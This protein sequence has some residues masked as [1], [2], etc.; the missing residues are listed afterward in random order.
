MQNTALC[1]PIFK[2]NKNKHFCGAGSH[3]ELCGL[4][5]ENVSM[6]H[7]MFQVCE[8][9]NRLPY[10]PRAC[11]DL[12]KMVP[13]PRLPGHVAP[14]SAL[15]KYGRALNDHKNVSIGNICTP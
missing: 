14:S 11:Q 8:T 5:L 13:L 7:Q 9:R 15:Y 6:E 2:A 1:N 12:F 10:E 3:G 4:R